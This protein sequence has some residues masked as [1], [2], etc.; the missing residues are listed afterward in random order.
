MRLWLREFSSVPSHVHFDREI[1]VRSQAE[2]LGLI[3]RR[4]VLCSILWPAPPFFPLNGPHYHGRR[5]PHEKNYH[6]DTQRNLSYR[7]GCRRLAQRL[8]P[9]IAGKKCL[10]YAPLRGA[11]PIWKGIRQF[12]A[13]TD[14]E[15]YFAVTSSFVFYPEAFRIHNKKGRPASGRLTNVLELGRRIKPVLGRN[16]FL[17]YVDEI[18][19]G[20]MMK[21]Y[22]QE[23]LDLGLDRLTPIIAVGLADR[24]GERSLTKRRMIER[25]REQG[26]I[27][28]FLWEGCE[29]LI[30]EDNR[31][32]LGMHYVDYR[33]GPHAVPMWAQDAPGRTLF[34]QEKIE[35][36]REALGKAVAANQEAEK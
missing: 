12:L 9:L 11:L 14:C 21:G 28:D 10:V 4:E 1:E 33:L 17:V 2:W 6:N 3:H 22:L 16:D 23:M 26:R 29:S 36:D 18:V 5:H 25:F 30:T 32:L 15:T 7:E 13:G 19:S 24:F 35:F 20:G 27:H 8:I 31:Y 34:P